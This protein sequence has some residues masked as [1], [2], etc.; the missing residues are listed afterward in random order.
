M[1][2]GG[3]RGCVQGRDPSSHE[4]SDEVAADLPDQLSDQS[5]AAR[6]I[7]LR[8]LT[9]GPRTRHQLA[10]KLRQRGIRAETAEATLD[11]LTEVGLID[12]AAFASAWV[13]SRASGRGL[14]RR[15]LAQELRTKGIDPALAEAAL[16]TLDAETQEDSARALVERKLRTTA[17]QPLQAQTRRLVA[18]LQR[19]GYDGELAFR[20]VREALE[21]AA[22]EDADDISDG[23][24]GP[25]D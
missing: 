5:E 8:Q 7:A 4:E 21:A 16:G 1:G 3:R 18:M 2:M 13:T 9:L 17:G 11:R 10:E 12:D 14:G 22:G 25:Y 15:V 20:V 19:K 24:S 23:F 6:N